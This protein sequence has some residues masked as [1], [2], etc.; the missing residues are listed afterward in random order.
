GNAPAR[1]NCREPAV[2]VLQEARGAVAAQ[3]GTQQI[4]AGETIVQSPDEREEAVPVGI[5]VVGLRAG[6]RIQVCVVGIEGEVTLRAASH[7]AAT[8]IVEFG[9]DHY[10]EV[11][12]VRERVGIQ[13]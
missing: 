13:E 8:V 10:A 2:T 7:F 9:T 1:G 5:A 11:V 12:L 6:S 3:R 4:L